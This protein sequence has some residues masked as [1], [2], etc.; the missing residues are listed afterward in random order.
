MWLPLNLDMKTFLQLSK[1]KA[2]EIK[3]LAN[4]KERDK[5]GLFLVEGS[6]N[7]VDCVGYFPPAFLIASDSWL[8]QNPDVT[9]KWEGEIF[10]S[11][12]R[13]IEIISSLNSLPEVIAV[14]HKPSP[15]SGI[16]VLEDGKIYLL[17]DEIQDPGNLGT[18][19]RTCDWF[20]VYD[21]FASKTTVDVFS[22]KVV[23]ATMGSL[24]R[25]RVHY[26]DLEELI[27]KNSRLPLV[28]TLL[29]G[30]PY[31]MQPPLKSGMVLMGNEGRGISEN[32]KK[33]VDIPLTIPPVN[34]EFH[35]DS[36]NVAIATAVILSEL[37]V[38]RQNLTG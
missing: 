29:E 34:P 31:D 4:K 5:T 17:L 1:T 7:V 33:R 12:R 21:I 14:F 28:G 13:G 24:S 37:T 30:T 11:D 9:E 20:G 8:S 18:I 35:P 36:L 38:K 19:I 3:S 2:K 16:P 22:P 23:Q 25:V 32:L 27:E 6:K 15:L 10:S 26:L